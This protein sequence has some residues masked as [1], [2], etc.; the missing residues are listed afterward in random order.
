MGENFQTDYDTAQQWIAD[1]AR[2]INADDDEAIDKP[3]HSLDPETVRAL[4]LLVLPP[5]PQGSIT[6]RNLQT[7]FRRFCVVA[8]FVDDDLASRGFQAL[9]L[10]MTQAGITTSRASL[11]LLHCELADII[12]THR[13]GRS[14]DARK[15]YSERATAVW[16]MRE[17]KPTS[18]ARKGAQDQP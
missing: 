7:A 2:E 9:A 10:A 5:M 12:G 14:Q 11:S 1:Q 15:S 8:C 16:A 13:L 4:V 6:P 18:R 3:T 17:R